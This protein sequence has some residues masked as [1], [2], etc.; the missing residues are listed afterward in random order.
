MQIE[1]KKQ[2]NQVEKTD[3]VHIKVMILWIFKLDAVVNGI[4]SNTQN[5]YTIDGDGDSEEKHVVE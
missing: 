3:Q 4:C 2:Q 5:G 1:A